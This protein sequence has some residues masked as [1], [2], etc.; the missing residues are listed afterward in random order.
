MHT[1][2]A[3]VHLSGGSA[4]AVGAN[5]DLREAKWRAGVSHGNHGA[6]GINGLMHMPAEKDAIRCVHVRDNS[7]NRNTSLQR[8]PAA[9]ECA[10]HASACA[11]ELEINGGTAD[12]RS[13]QRG[14]AAEV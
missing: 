13:T 7:P 10:L 9:G 12:R 8:G 3:A 1:K 4:A 11:C 6:K 2:N 5:D 14:R